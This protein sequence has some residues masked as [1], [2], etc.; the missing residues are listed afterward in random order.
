MAKKQM[1]PYLNK[2]LTPPSSLIYVL[3]LCCLMV[4]L[5]ASGSG[6]MD[7]VSTIF[8]LNIICFLLTC[9]HLLPVLFKEHAW[10]HCCKMLFITPRA[11]F[12]TKTVPSGNELHKFLIWDTAGQERV[13]ASTT[14]IPHLLIISFKLTH[15][16]WLL[17]STFS[18]TFCIRKLAVTQSFHC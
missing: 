14:E 5:Y 16:T 6:N 17:K 9:T 3:A 1:K 8:I 15:I 12:L 7:L 13:S 10:T 4:V 11:S 2:C 18:V